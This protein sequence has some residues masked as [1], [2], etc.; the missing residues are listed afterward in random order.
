MLSRPK[1]VFLLF[2]W[3]WDF[4]E[5]WLG[6]CIL[7]KLWK[8]S[9]INW[10]FV[11]FVALSSCSIPISLLP[12]L[13]YVFPCLC[14]IPQTPESLLVCE[15]NIWFRTNT[16]LW[17]TVTTFEHRDWVQSWVVFRGV[18]I[19]RF[20]KN[21]DTNDCLD[22]VTHTELKFNQLHTILSLNSHFLSSTDGL[23]WRLYT[24]LMFGVDMTLC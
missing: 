15:I 8:F 5:W 23:R 10:E 20:Y 21:H 2:L 19:S 18:D 14:H 11:V 12:S 13:N 16:G 1:N 7:W 22:A 9:K 3:S 6:W 17:C 4:K 24:P